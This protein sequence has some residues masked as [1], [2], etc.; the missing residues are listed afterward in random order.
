MNLKMTVMEGLRAPRLLTSVPEFSAGT[1]AQGPVGCAA[2]RVPVSA[3]QHGSISVPAPC[4]SMQ[5]SWGGL[6]KF[7]SIAIATNSTKTF[8]Q[9]AVIRTSDTYAT[10]ANIPLRGRHN[11]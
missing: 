3:V 6:G 8:R 2:G 11:V 9:Q 7:A 4:H 10:R 1:R 5:S